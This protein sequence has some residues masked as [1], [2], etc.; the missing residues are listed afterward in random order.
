MTIRYNQLD[1]FRIRRVYPILAV[2]LGG[3]AMLA[4]CATTPHLYDP[5]VETQTAAIKEA[6]G[7]IANETYFKDLRAAFSQLQTEEDAVRTEFLVA[8][9]DE[10]LIRA[11]K[12]TGFGSLDR[13]PRADE[14]APAYERCGTVADGGV[15]GAQGPLAVCEESLLRLHQ[16]IGACPPPGSGQPT[17]LEKTP[18]LRRTAS[19]AD[20]KGLCA[21]R[22][23]EANLKAWTNT[24]DLVSGLR[25]YI[26]AN[27]G[28]VTST[29]GAFTAARDEWRKRVEAAWNEANPAPPKKARQKKTKVN[30][31]EG[32]E[33]KPEER[34]GPPQPK[35]DLSCTA[36]LSIQ[37]SLKEALG[38]SF[39]DF[40]WSKLEAVREQCKLQQNTLAL[41]DPETGY[42][43]RSFTPVSTRAPASQSDWSVTLREAL[44]R[45]EPQQLV[46]PEV[47]RL[48]REARKL[49]AE[50]ADAV[51]RAKAVEEALKA[52]QKQVKDRKSEDWQIAARLKEA[53]EAIAEA[54]PAARLVGA[55]GWADLLEDL[56]AAELH[57]ASN[58]ESGSEDQ[59]ENAAAPVPAQPS[60]ANAAASGAAPATG[61]TATDTVAA[62]EDSDTEEDKSKTTE[63][64]EAVLGALA[65]ME[66]L[67][68]AARL[69]DPAQRVS[70]LLIAIAAK[71]QEADV[72]ALEQKRADERLAV[73]DAQELTLATEIMF[74]AEAINLS[75]TLPNQPLGIVALDADKRGTASSAL[76]RYA[77]SWSEGRIPFT[78]LEQRKTYINRE[79]RIRLAERTAANWKSLLEPAITQLEAA[80]ACCIRTEAV[81]GLIGQFVSGAALLER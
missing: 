52:L 33:A 24:L 38:P 54:P 55:N 4:G 26:A 64:T 30:R 36:L 59:S 69:S 17:E 50:R 61:T 81:T 11:I 75:R 6:Y 9:R 58:K 80:G 23:L 12:P 79:F 7:K 60:V 68:E 35:I 18:H 73:I 31:A 40:P 70:A 20:L 71:R 43:A 46:E 42:L 72:A 14:V 32:G 5:S 41:A 39:S 74:L 57:V 63:R 49:R 1:G 21:P 67:S 77:L 10:R 3:G 45:G 19:A 2:L 47:V 76:N 78:L 51:V 25:T 13:E 29:T 65:A 22:L 48:A 44:G 8:Q 28:M 15:Y 37:G 66:R 56:L 16:I 27:E 53:K 34:K 62:A